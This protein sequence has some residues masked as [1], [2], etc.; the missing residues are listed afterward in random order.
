MSAFTESVVEDAALAWLQAIGWPVAHGPDIAPDMPAAERAN[1]NEVVLGTRLRDALARLNPMLPADALEDA[2]RKLT[3]PEGADLIQRNRALHRLLANGVTVEYRTREGEVRG[4]Q[5]RVIDFDKPEANDWLAVNQ[6]SVTENKH[7]RR[8]DVVLFV[9]GLPLAVLELKNA[10][11]ENATIWSAFQQLQTYQAEIPSLFATNAVLVVSDG[12][13]ARVGALG[14][15]R[16][17]F[18][19][20]RTIAGERLA[21]SHVPELQVVIEGVFAPRRFLDLVR[22]FLVF[23]D[24]GSGRLIKKMAGYHQFH[25]VQVAVGETLR[26]AE[27][28]RVGEEAGRYEAGRK[29]GGKPGDRR[30]GVVWHT[31]G[32]G[33][34]LTMA[35]YAGRIIRE[36]AMENPTVVVL[37]DRNELDD[38]LFG[39]FSRCADLL[40]QPPVQAES[41][42]HLRE[43][44]SVAAGGVVFTTIHK[45]FPEEKGDRHPTLSER[46]N[47]VVMADEA[48]RSQYDFIDGYARHMRD[49]LPHASFIGF[50]G[51]PIELQDANTRAVFG[52][53]ISVYDIRRAVQDG[54]TVP[55]Y[56]E[57]RL[58]KLTLDETERP[59]IDPDFEEATEGE[60]IERKEKL[61]SKWAQLEAVVGADKRLELVARDIVEH[62]EKRLEAMDGKAMIVCMSRRICVELYR[63]IVKLRPDW[64][65][66]D[67]ARGAI[68]VVMTGS[69]SDPSDWQA[70]I[71]NK[72]RREALANRFRD[73]ADPLRIVLV[74]DMWL[75]GFDAPCMHTMYIDKPM[76]GHGLMQAIARVNRVFKDKPGGLVVDYLGLAHELKA[77]LATYTESGGT[78]RTALDQE[79][80]VALMLEKYEV[81][82]GLFHGFDRSRWTTGTPA[83]RLALLPAAQEHILAKEDGKDRCLRAV[84]ELSQ[85]FALA[86]PHEEALRI[87]DDVAFFQAVQAVLAKRAPNDAR[88][89][90]DLDHAVRQIISRA[91]SPEGVVDIF[92]A[93]GLQKPDISILSD[94]FLAE[95]RGMPQRNLAV[96]LLQKLLKGELATRRRKNVVQARSFAEMLEQTLR[97]YQNR[98]IEAAQVIEELIALAKE[99]REANARGENLGLTEEELAFYDALETNDSAVKVLG[100]DTLRDIA[101]ELVKTVRN[102]VTIDWTLRENVRAQLRVL[103]KR[104]LRKH[105]YPP[106]KQE[107]A[108][109]T[110]LEQAALLS[111]EWAVACGV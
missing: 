69:A 10:A 59:K 83:E 30:V 56:Y 98:A 1:Y 63:E 111:A 9:N 11:D 19:P 104:I 70:H 5:A 99:M 67:D 13:Q 105:G 38:Q 23:E 88:P 14:A 43:L 86:V 94:E 60:E 50:T 74:R 103:V 41:R 36:P 28:A 58:A 34:S 7:S 84:R 35:F 53:Y 26:A 72:P 18:K 2:Y 12:T 54:A 75:T 87:R 39:T 97:R 89:E 55:I 102:N 32:S 44:L 71:R 40:R 77:A 101:R 95:V 66:E 91:V 24:D 110:V 49:A 80:A 27:L 64:H 82:C 45:F 37:T 21:D 78:G 47:I 68:K 25:A 6:F 22:D 79:E 51:T 20:W 3:R 90:E 29:P 46:R 93:A 108:T 92:A 33:K 106:D 100:D 52:D 62:F 96:E 73:A 85:A 31:Q 57:S 8:P 109:Q 4:A 16:E 65:D 17:W 42:A 15:G 81:C 107:K 48:H 76:R 61:K